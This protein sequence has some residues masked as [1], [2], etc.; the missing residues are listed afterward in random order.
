M[1]HATFS[2]VDEAQVVIMKVFMC[3]VSS[4]EIVRLYDPI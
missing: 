4:R 2:Q 3:W 1:A